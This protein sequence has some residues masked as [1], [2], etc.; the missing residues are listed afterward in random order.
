MKTLEEKMFIEYR[1][2]LKLFLMKWK[3]AEKID[4][5]PVKMKN[6]LFWLKGAYE[7]VDYELDCEVKNET[8]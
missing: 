7:Q 4:N 8:I 5:L 3:L 2:E 6:S 1:N